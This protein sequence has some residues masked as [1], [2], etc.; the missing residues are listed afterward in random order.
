[1]EKVTKPNVRNIALGKNFIAKQM[2]PKAGFYLIEKVYNLI[3]RPSIL[4]RLW[5]IAR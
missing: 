2:H 4:F 1:M 3:K 5:K